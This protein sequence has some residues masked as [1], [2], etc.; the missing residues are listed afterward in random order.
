M[1]LAAP[2]LERFRQSVETL[3]AEGATSSLS[4]AAAARRLG[5]TSATLARL[6]PAAYR[7]F[8][9]RYRAQRRQQRDARTAQLAADMRAIMTQQAAAGIYP[10]AKRVRPLLHEPI[11][12]CNSD[13]NRIRHQLLY[14]LGW[15]LGGARSP[16]P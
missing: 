2:E 15:S 14:E 3:L 16:R 10:A 7:T 13:F 1:A 11:H 9:D 12:P 5:C 8:V 4:A 6:H